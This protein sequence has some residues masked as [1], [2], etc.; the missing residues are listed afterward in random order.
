MGAEERRAR[1][2]QRHRG[3]KVHGEIM[4]K[5]LH[6]SLMWL[7]ATKVLRSGARCRTGKVGLGQD[8][9]DFIC[10]A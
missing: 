8:V 9:K 5:K 6:H 10:H 1:H 2:Q 4:V 3:I 7:R